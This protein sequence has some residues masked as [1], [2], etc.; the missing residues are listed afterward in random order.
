MELGARSRRRLLRKLAEKAIANACETIH[1]RLARY[2][3][4]FIKYLDRFP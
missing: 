2:E 1:S 4:E 3:T